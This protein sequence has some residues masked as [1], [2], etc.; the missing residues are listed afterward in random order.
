MF[1][2][3]TPNSTVNA[4]GEECS[5]NIPNTVFGILPKSVFFLYVQCCENNIWNN[6]S[7]VRVHKLF[8]APSINV[9]QLLRMKDSK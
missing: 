5:E 6:S 9:L 7:I 2:K 8:L 1:L 4:F 3:R